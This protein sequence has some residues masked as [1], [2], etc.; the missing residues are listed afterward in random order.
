MIT[1]AKKAEIIS[2]AKD[3][4][5]SSEMCAVVSY[6]NMLVK[7]LEPLRRSLYQSNSHLKTIKKTL[8][9]IVLD[10]MLT[11]MPDG[12][13]ALICTKGDIFQ[14]IKTISKSP[15]QYITGILQDSILNEEQMKKL[16][17]IESFAQLYN[18]IVIA[19]LTPLIKL[20]SFFKLLF[21]KIR[22]LLEVIHGN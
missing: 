13:V 10:N 17:R 22:S 12:N 8:L 14:A 4:I 5:S 6:K 2:S 16:S 9:N 21:F 7:D 18:S 11:D 3:D 1:R 20:L 19:I 15:L